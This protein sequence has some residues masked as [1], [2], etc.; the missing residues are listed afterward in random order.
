MSLEFDFDAKWK[1]VLHNAIIND[2]MLEVMESGKDLFQS[3]L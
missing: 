3:L 1:N 2:F